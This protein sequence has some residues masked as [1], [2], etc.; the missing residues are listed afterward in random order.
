MARK[1]AQ[2]VCQE[3]GYKHSKWSGRCTSCGAWNSLVEN[4]PKAS[5]MVSAA[6][7]GRAL[8]GTLVGSSKRVA[9]SRTSSMISD[10]DEVLGGGFV[11]GSVNLVAGQPGIGKSTLLM[12]IAANISKTKKLM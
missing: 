6:L 3:C 12:Q 10:V 2:F 1:S 8:K 9:G 7:K 4:I 5:G 11:E